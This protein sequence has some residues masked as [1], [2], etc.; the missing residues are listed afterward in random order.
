MVYS[1]GRKITKLDDEI[2]KLARDCERNLNVIDV[3]DKFSEEPPKHNQHSRYP[4]ERRY[5]N[6]NFTNRSSNGNDS[7]RKES[8]SQLSKPTVNRA[9]AASVASAKFQCVYDFFEDQPIQSQHV[10][11]MTLLRRSLI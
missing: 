5:N 11:R 10:S 4:T 7:D 8:G 9:A 2:F 6:N 1:S 3:T